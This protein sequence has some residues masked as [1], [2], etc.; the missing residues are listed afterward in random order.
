MQTLWCNSLFLSSLQ[1][2]GSLP[3]L[4]TPVG[5]SSPQ[6]LH[7]SYSL[8]CSFF[9]ILNYGVCSPSLWIIF[10]VIYPDVS[11]IQLY[12]W[13]K[14]SLEAS[15]LLSFQIPSMNIY[16]LISF[17]IHY[18]PL[19]ADRDQIFLLPV[20]L[21]SNFQY[22]YTTIYQINNKYLHY[23]DHI[24]ITHCRTKNGILISFPFLQHFVFFWNW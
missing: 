17:D 1:A 8:Q 3:L 21:P 15:I 11:V 20:M 12:S 5:F 7:P 6:H 19:M 2:G 13:N 16:D 23:Y 14:V 22:N 10:W 4:T 18:L 9:F 24:S